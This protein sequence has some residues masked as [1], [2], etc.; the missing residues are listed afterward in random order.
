MKNKLIFFLCTCTLLFSCETERRIDRE[1][2]DGG[3]KDME[4]KKI[5]EIDITNKAYEMGD[6][7]STAA[8]QEL[9]STLTRAIEEK[10]VAGA[11]DFCNLEA[12][13]L[14]QKVGE[15]YNAQVRR[16][17]NRYRNPQ[18]QPDQ[19]EEML[20][21]AYEYNVE[22]QIQS[23]PNVQKIQDGQVLLYTKAIQIP[24]QLCLNCHG[25]PGVDI[26]REVMAKINE[27]YPEDKA[28]G[29]EIGDL[30]GMWSIR[31]SRKEVIRNL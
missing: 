14:L 27:L 6:E 23:S 9:M 20:L 16:V 26:D 3:R 31:I 1:A 5:S 17:S 30:R 4:V 10:G 22:N 28:T 29:H 11:V 8:Q 21:S 18:D 24:G 12:L 7:I 13:P 2:Y 25:E 19:E 15:S